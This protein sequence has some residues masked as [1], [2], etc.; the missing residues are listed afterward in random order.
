[1]W[2]WIKAYLGIFKDPV[3]APTPPR[4]FGMKEAREV[5]LGLAQ[6]GKVP[7]AETWTAVRLSLVAVGVSD[8]VEKETEGE[9]ARLTNHSQ[10]DLRQAES[11]ETQARALRESSTFEAAEAGL[12]RGHLALYVGA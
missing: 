11:L 8:L 12:L 2:Q 7:T 4:K 1:M 5:R 10:A 6:A 3:V 9:I